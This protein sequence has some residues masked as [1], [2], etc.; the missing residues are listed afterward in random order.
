MSN[1]RQEPT[2]GRQSSKAASEPEFHRSERSAPPNIRADLGD[3]HDSSVTESK[4]SSGGSGLAVFALLLGLVSL[5]G[6]AFLYMQLEAAK[7]SGAQAEARIVELESKLTVTG[8]ESE[9]SLAALQARIKTLADA[10]DTADSE[11]RKL[12]AIANERN[13]KAITEQEKAVGALQNQVSKLDGSVDK[14]IAAA[15]KDNLSTIQTE[16]A[17][18][19]DLVDAQQSAITKAENQA[20]AALK[21]A[22]AAQEK[23]V[24]DVQSIK[25]RLADTDEAIKAFDAFRLSVSRDLTKLT[26]LTNPTSPSP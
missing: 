10:Q 24:S 9:Q 25:K 26:N 19:N 2:L 3:D 11:I 22:N 5:G 18:V 13:K 1:R 21:S 4:G 14:K 12:W 17:L 8:D 16:L 7:L 6:C 15:L 20:Q 23:V